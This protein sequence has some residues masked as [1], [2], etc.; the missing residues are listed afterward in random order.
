MA[1]GLPKATIIDSHNM[2]ARV[3]REIAI[4]IRAA[5]PA[6][7]GQHYRGLLGVNLSVL[8]A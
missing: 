2:R 1:G 7:H 5:S 4:C 3:G 6:L 8:R